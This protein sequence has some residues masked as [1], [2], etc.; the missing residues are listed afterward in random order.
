MEENSKATGYI[1]WPFL[2]WSTKMGTGGSVAAEEICRRST[3]LSVGNWLGKMTVHERTDI[4]RQGTEPVTG[5]ERRA[6]AALVD[7]GGGATPG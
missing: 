3:I 1:P 4:E 5:L 7:A 2:V 6:G